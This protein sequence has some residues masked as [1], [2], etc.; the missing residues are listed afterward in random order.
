[1]LMSHAGRRGTTLFVSLLLHAGL[2]LSVVALPLFLA[3]ALPSQDVKAF[4]PPL[5]LAPPLPPPPPP[6]RAR[7]PV[8]QAAARAGTRLVAPHVE[9]ELVP[10]DEALLGSEDAVGDGDGVPGGLPNGVVGSVLDE[11]PTSA[12]LPPR[13]VRISSGIAAPR[14]VRRVDPAY[15]ALAAAARVSATVELEAEVDVRGE[16]VRVRVER[17]H[18]L[19]DEAALA[20]VRQ[21]RYQPLLLSGAPTAFVLTVTV[22][23]ELRR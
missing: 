3:E 18:P 9:S 11:L 17:G 20:A 22:R 5:A 2:A 21:W 19:F 1:M 7:L 14:L 12:P 6:G 8:R 16:V 10:E 13:V 15:P 23:F 4:L